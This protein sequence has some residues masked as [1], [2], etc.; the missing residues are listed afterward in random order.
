MLSRPL[1]L[2]F[3]FWLLIMVT[4]FE[5][6]QQIVT[7][8]EANPVVSRRKQRMLDSEE[9]VKEKIILSQEKS[10]QQ[11][12]DLVQSLKQQLLH[13]RGINN[14]VHDDGNTLSEKM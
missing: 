2:V 7:E 10:I 8:A 5:Q 14:S 4:H 6:R 12:H 13:C 9:V 1:L 3:L 11:L